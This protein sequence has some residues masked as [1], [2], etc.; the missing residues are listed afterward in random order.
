MQLDGI[1]AVAMVGI[2]WDHWC[3]AGWPRI[4]PFEVFLFFFLVLTGYLI[5]GSLLREQERH[6]GLGGAWRLK[7]LK[8]YQLRRGLRILVPYYLALLLG[9]LVCAPDLFVN[10]GWYFFHLSNLHMATLSY[11]PT[12]TNHFWSLAMQQQFYLIWPFVIWFTPRKWLI[13]TLLG[14]SMVGP[15]SRMFQDSFNPWFASPQLLTWMAFDYFG[16]GSLL[17]LAIHEKMPWQ[18]RRLKW[19][20]GSGLVGYCLIVTA[21][22]L[23]LPTW[24]FRAFQQSFLSLALCGLIAIGTLGLPGRWKW[25]F[26]NPAI[27]RVGQLSYGIYL[28]HNL[29]PLVTGKLF[30]FLWSAPFNNDWGAV[31]RVAIFAIV[32]WMLALACW[33]WVESPLQAV[34]S[35]LKPGPTGADCE[36][37][38]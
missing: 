13:L 19:V 32:T 28:F 37:S 14:F 3:P 36:S 31:L 11:W 21:H 20:V 27:Q 17:A 38:P 33:K 22:R 29:A 6:R 4:F 30:W 26:E 15:F 10:F 1:R 25:L 12:G 9:L 5:T 35:R 16:V 18:S 24:G 8:N 7:A 2:C 34:R 23:H